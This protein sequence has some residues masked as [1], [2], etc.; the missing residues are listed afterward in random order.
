MNRVF[1]VA[2]FSIL[3]AW[4][5]RAQ[6]LDQLSQTS[7]E[8]VI[9]GGTIP[10]QIRFGD[11]DKSWRR[12][13]ISGSDDDLLSQIYSSNARNPQP[14][15]FYTLGQTL[16]MNGES[17]LVTYK[18][19]PI[20]ETL[21]TPD[22]F[23][24]G[25]LQIPPALTTQTALELALLNPRLIS[26]FSAIRVLDVAQEIAQNAAVVQK[27]REQRIKAINASSLNH[28]QQLGQ[29]LRSYTQ[30]T[31]KLPPLQTSAAA[32]KVMRRFG[33]SSP[34]P[35]VNPATEKNYAVNSSLS[36]K[37]LKQIVELSITIVFYEAESSGDGT[38]GVVF[39]DG[40]AERIPES[41]FARLRSQTKVSPKAKIVLLHGA[42]ALAYMYDKHK[43]VKP[44]YYRTAVG[45]RIY[46][47]DEKTKRPIFVSPPR[48]P[49]MVPDFEA[50]KY[51]NYA[52]YNGRKTGQTFGGYGY[53]PQVESVN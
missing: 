30:S 12:M 14:Q 43:N 8:A 17:F 6:N 3:A 23:G 1:V 2:T 10:L 18:I 16:T 33:Y 34:S 32:Q 20:V 48:Q 37:S 19:A 45:D 27:A 28:L 51:H 24:N 22:R 50:V 49:L 53:I 9:S 5:S 7:F 4:P 35:F 47:R 13:Q 38:R 26:R 29:Q 39:A 46:Y 36:G 44:F 42:S 21:P 41:E 25:A 40:S 52:G 31:G 11:M 15:I